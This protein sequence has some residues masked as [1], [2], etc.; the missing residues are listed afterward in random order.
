MR[1]VRQQ[2]RRDD[3]DTDYRPPA[4]IKAHLCHT[5]RGYPADGAEGR[6]Q[7]RVVRNRQRVRYDWP[8]DQVEA[9]K[10]QELEDEQTKKSRLQSLNSDIRQMLDS[11]QTCGDVDITQHKARPRS[12]ESRQ[13]VRTIWSTGEQA[14][15]DQPD[16][17]WLSTRLMTRRQL[18]T[19]TRYF[20]E[21]RP[22]PWRRITA[23]HNIKPLP[24]RIP[25]ASFQTQRVPVS[26]Q[27]PPEV[28]SSTRN[29]YERKISDCSGD[30]SA[31]R[32]SSQGG[33][34][35]DIESEASFDSKSFEHAIAS[36]ADWDDM[37][38]VQ[39][40][41]QLEA[42]RLAQL[43][44][45][46]E[47]VSRFMKR[48]ERRRSRSS[49]FDMVFIKRGSPANQTPRQ[50]ETIDLCD[51]D[52]EEREWRGMEPNKLDLAREI[53]A[54]R[55]IIS[56]A[57]ATPIEEHKLL[58]T[59]EA[60]EALAEMQ[61]P[62]PASTSVA[63]EKRNIVGLGLGPLSSPQS[64][65]RMSSMETHFD[66]THDEDV[67]SGATSAEEQT[68]ALGFQGLFNA[69]SLNKGKERQHEGHTLDTAICV[70][71]SDCSD[72]GQK[73]A[74]TSFRTLHVSNAN[75]KHSRSRILRSI[76]AEEATSEIQDIVRQMQIDE[77][78]A[79]DRYDNYSDLMRN[80]HLRIPSR[81]NSIPPFDMPRELNLGNATSGS[82]SDELQE[83]DC[84]SL[85]LS[86]P[87]PREG[88][89]RV[90]Q[91]PMHKTGDPGQSHV[92]P[93]AVLQIEIEGYTAIS[94]V[95]GKRKRSATS[96]GRRSTPPRP[97]AVP[98]SHGRCSPVR[99][100]PFKG[101]D[102][103]KHARK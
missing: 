83:D 37:V 72:G 28:K 6:P 87:V 91:Q 23:F 43:L 47:C 102:Q 69:M 3:D 74:C 59:E 86:P 38:D 89:F 57:Q 68:E 30:P 44:P 61:S 29:D 39:N 16:L 45:F 96:L 81:Q 11:E 53:M 88:L 33:Y 98:C 14:D 84:A 79:C 51:S 55:R 92:S 17:P 65:T 46:A 2:P 80:A 35:S 7:R 62:A 85:H 71:D 75:Q 99:I 94:R 25:I 42:V 41:R 20:L 76:I 19:G 93:K 8:E 50:V 52:V 66:L 48:K 56:A 27:R 90:L 22:I 58:R 1:L 4:I 10:L 9:L 24:E 95:L 15:V 18:E 54:L 64:S 78:Y 12:A 36:F 73:Q 32:D 67:E 82:E 26:T 77:A 21:D 97:S 49:S 101:L 40:A 63:I 31:A 34:C 100:R 70:S 103:R 13:D 60:P 5:A